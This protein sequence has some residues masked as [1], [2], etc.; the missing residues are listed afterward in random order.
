M[1]VVYDNWGRLVQAVQRREQY[2]EMAHADSRSTS[3][4]SSISFDLDDLSLSLPREETN[5]E[6][7]GRS[8]RSDYSSSQLL[9][10]PVKGIENDLRSKG[11][12]GNGSKS[13]NSLISSDASQNELE[14]IE[15][16]EKGVYLTVIV[17]QDGS[18][19]IKRARFRYFPLLF[20]TVIL[21]IAI[22][23]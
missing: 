1:P 15:Q 11:V 12:H 16:Y 13:Q 14:W 10:D 7:E 6:N 18:R 4:A 3:S 19:D 20:F 23:C 8:S 5:I 21:D 2:W 22:Y 17:F 9:N